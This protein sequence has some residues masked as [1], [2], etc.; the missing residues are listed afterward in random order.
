MT[1][2]PVRPL[3]L[4]KSWPRR[5]RSALLQAIALTGVTLLAAHGQTGSNHPSRSRIEWLQ[6]EILLP[7]ADARHAGRVLVVDVP[8]G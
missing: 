5:V 4:P 1:R 3:I 8:T 6:Q 2:R 7:K